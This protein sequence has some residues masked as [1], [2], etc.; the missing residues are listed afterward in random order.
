MKEQPLWSRAGRDSE[1]R[2]Y[3]LLWLPSFHH[4]VC[5]RVDHSSQGT[6]LHARV[7]DGAGGYDPGQVAID[8]EVA[9]GHHQWRELERLVSAAAFWEMPTRTPEDSGGSDGDQLIVEA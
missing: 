4:P 7:L 9:L 6:R 2:I 5:V 1:T 8:R 3:R